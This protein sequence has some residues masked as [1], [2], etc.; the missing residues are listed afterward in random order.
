MLLDKMNQ[1]INIT[2]FDIGKK[3]IEDAKKGRFF[4]K[5]LT[6]NK[7]IC[8]I[9][10]MIYAAF[11]DDYLVFKTNTPLSSKQLEY[12][13][14]FNEFFTEIPNKKKLTIV[15]CIKRLIYKDFLP[16]LCTKEFQIKPEK[17]KTCKFLQGDIMK[18]DEIV[19][20]QSAD[21]L[22]FRNAF[23]H[24]TTIEDPADFKTE[25]PEE[26]VVPAV[27]HFVMQIDKAVAKN[28]LFVL[29]E[30]L[31][32]HTNITGKTLYKEL[33]KHNFIHA[34]EKDYLVTVWQKTE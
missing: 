22:L 12:K 34:L 2:G 14:M 29:G 18:L 25:L 6:G 7:E 11:D 24:L 30:H 23:Y 19:P 1:K 15:E 9:H 31:S 26:F 27:E 4:I 20:P 8:S 3:A 5:T 16:N 10:K 13:Q 28:G 32:D 17:A 33:L 21:V